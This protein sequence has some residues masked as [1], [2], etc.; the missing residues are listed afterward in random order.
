MSVGA[1][2]AWFALVVAT[3]LS[4]STLPE[5]AAPKG[6][7]V[8]A[9]SVD[10]SDVISYRTLTRADFKSET[11]P[12]H[13]TN[14]S[15][16]VGALTCCHIYTMPSAQFVTRRLHSE[17]QPP[18]YEATLGQLQFGAQMDRRCSWWNPKEVGFP[19][20]YILEHEQIHFAL[21]E[22]EARRLNASIVEIEAKLSATASSP[23]AAG[24]LVQEEISE[25]LRDR[26]RTILSRSRDF[27]EDTSMGHEPDAQKEWWA[28]VH[29]ELAATADQAAR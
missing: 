13:L 24:E 22:L 28:R 19:Q 29:A 15:E 20:D 16:R 6:T 14:Y 8:D 2:L 25:Y 18:K 23:T 9:E 27:D 21:C 4:C 5:H 26:M 12:P 3:L 11:L 17:D 10:R 1:R 7:V